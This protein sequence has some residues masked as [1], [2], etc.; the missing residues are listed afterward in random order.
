VLL[1][2]RRFVARISCLMLFLSVLSSVCTGVLSAD[3]GCVLLVVRRF[4]ANRSFLC[5]VFLSVCMGKG[6]MS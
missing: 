2:V 3:S 6:I 1:V 5:I 4:V